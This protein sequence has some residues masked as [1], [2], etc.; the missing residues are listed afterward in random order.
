MPRW[1]GGVRCASTVLGYAGASRQRRGPPSPYGPGPMDVLRTP[2]DRFADLPGFPFE[3][4]YVEVDAGDGSGDA[5]RVHY[6]DEGP[7]PTRPRRC[8]CCTASRRGR[9]STAR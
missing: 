2:D 1:Y 3:P 4:H 8:C 6:V 5:L 7:R 9:T